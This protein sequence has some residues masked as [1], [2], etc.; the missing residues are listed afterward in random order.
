MLFKEECFDGET[1][2]FF[3]QIL[4]ARPEDSGT[5]VCTAR[6]N[7]GSTETKVEVTVEGDSQALS[8]PRVSVPEPLMIVVE[9][10]TATLHCEAHGNDQC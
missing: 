1:Y 3:V 2:P 4:V 8:V 9:G 10:K 5:Y 7:E 6:N